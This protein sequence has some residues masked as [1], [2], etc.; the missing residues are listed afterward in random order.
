MRKVWIVVANSSQAK[1]FRA[2]NVQTLVE[3]KSFVHEESQEPSRELTSDRQ[4]RQTSRVGYGTDTYQEQTTTKAKEQSQFAHEIADFL[5]QGYHSG[6]Y[7]RLY[8]I[9]KPPFLGY[10]RQCLNGNVSKLVESEIQKDL[11]QLKP[12]QI[13]EYLP[14]VL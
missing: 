8:L 5:A 13:R 10:L 6:E 3:Y 12:G 4:G 1:I 14:P 2:E 11:T 7:E 9:S